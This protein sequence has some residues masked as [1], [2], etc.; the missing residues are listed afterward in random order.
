LKKSRL[1]LFGVFLIFFGFDLFFLKTVS[2]FNCSP[3]FNLQLT[4]NA[5]SSGFQPSLSLPSSCGLQVVFRRQHFCF[6][7]MDASQGTSPYTYRESWSVNAAGLDNFA[8]GGRSHAAQNYG[9]VSQAG[10]PVKT[11]NRPKQSPPPP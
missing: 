1:S 3:S 8:A 6:T 11:L 9:Q 2:V 7:E 5:S 4:S 10:N